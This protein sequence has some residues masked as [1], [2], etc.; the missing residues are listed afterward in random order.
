[1]VIEIKQEEPDMTGP[2][3]NLVREYNMEEKIMVGSF[4]DIAMENFRRI[5]PEIATSPSGGDV[6]QFVFLNFVFLSEIINPTYQVFQV[7]VENS[8]ITVI[9]E[10]FVKSAHNRNL[11]VQVWTINDPAEMERLIDLGVDGIMTDRPDI[12][13]AL[14]E[15]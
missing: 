5:C 14:L 9:T 8:G 11:Q 2:F 1:M 3:C 12:L 10:R 15:R 13:L 7:P 6:R 4:S